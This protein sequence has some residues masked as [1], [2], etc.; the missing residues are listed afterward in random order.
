MRI[1]SLTPNEI[2]KIDSI[3]LSGLLEWQAKAKESGKIGDFK[4]I[5]REFASEFELTDMEAINLLNL[6]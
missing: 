6:E 1:K 5:G 2:S 3:T 4:R